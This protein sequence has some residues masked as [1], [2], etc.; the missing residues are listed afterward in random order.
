MWAE[1]FGRKE[2]FA[3]KGKAEVVKRTRDRRIGFSDS[4]MMCNFASGGVS[5]AV[6]ACLVSS[7]VGPDLA[8]DWFYVLGDRVSTVESLQCT[9]RPP[10]QGRTLPRRIL[11]ESVRSGPSAGRALD[12]L[13]GLKEDFCRLCGWD[14]ASGAPCAEQTKEAC[15]ATW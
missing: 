11:T 15:L 9:R 3:R 1:I 5:D 14:L 12:F 4:A 8:P 6:L 2:L 13:A 7:V 10:S